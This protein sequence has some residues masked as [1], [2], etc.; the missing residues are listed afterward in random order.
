MPSLHAWLLWREGYWD[1]EIA[2]MRMLLA[3]DIAK[4]ASASASAPQGKQ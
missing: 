2:H 3:E 1:D 4:Q